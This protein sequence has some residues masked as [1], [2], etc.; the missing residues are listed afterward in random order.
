MAASAKFQT[1]NNVMPDDIKM[2]FI[3]KLEKMIADLEHMN[4]LFTSSEKA[5]IIIIS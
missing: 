3:S 2:G 1:D 4:R 5:T